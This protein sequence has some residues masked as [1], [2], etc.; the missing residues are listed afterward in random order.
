MNDSGARNHPCTHQKRKVNARGE[1]WFV[2][3]YSRSNYYDYPALDSLKFN[4]VTL[5]VDKLNDNFVCLVA[6]KNVIHNVTIA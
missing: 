2:L 1:K 6:L 5:V 3:V 4:N